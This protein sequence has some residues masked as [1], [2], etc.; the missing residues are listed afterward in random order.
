LDTV[1]LGVRLRH[2]SCVRR[3]ANARPGRGQQ[4]GGTRSSRG[5]RPAQGCWA[6]SPWWWQAKSS[7]RW[8]LAWPPSSRSSDF[9]T[10]TG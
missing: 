2:A 3:L 1:V 4:M 6:V 9:P 10:D 8:C 7:R 5:A